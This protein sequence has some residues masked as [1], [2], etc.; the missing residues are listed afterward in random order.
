MLAVVLISLCSTSGLRGR[1]ERAARLEPRRAAVFDGDR[2]D[3]LLAAAEKD[4]SALQYASA[5]LVADREFVLAVVGVNVEAMEW[6]PALR[7]DRAF[8]LEAVRR[9]GLALR[10]A[11]EALRGDREVVL[12]A[13]GQ[14]GGALRWA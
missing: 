4:P 5:D 14:T 10:W 7:G 1:G 3:A 2:R 13:V 12:A 9:N 6:A 8:V 11:S